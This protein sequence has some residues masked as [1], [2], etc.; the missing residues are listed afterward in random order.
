MFSRRRAVPKKVNHTKETLP[1]ENN[2]FIFSF[3]DWREPTNRLISLHP[4]AYLTS[5]KETPS[6]SSYQRHN[7]FATH[8]L[9]GCNLQQQGRRS[10]DVLQI[11]DCFLCG[12]AQ[13]RIGTEGLLEDNMQFLDVHSCYL[14]SSLPPS[15]NICPFSLSFRCVLRHSF[16]FDVLDDCSTFTALRSLKNNHRAR[17]RWGGRTGSAPCSDKRPSERTNKGADGGEK[18]HEKNPSV[19]ICGLSRAEQKWHNR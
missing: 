6:G 5:E 17:K 4:L 19:F 16:P 12:S 13:I 2:D 3:R 8:L 11:P 18:T 7:S 1:R 10:L 14:S 15:Q 9:L